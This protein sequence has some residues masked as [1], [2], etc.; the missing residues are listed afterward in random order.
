MH[1]T[2]GSGENALHIALGAENPDVQLIVFL[3]D[4][5]LDVDAEDSNGRTPFHCFCKVSRYSGY[6]KSEDVLTLLLSRSPPG[7]EKTPSASQETIKMNG[8]HLR[9]TNSYGCLSR[10][11]ANL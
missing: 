4:S 2:N 6:S 7:V 9:D 10:E 1:T 8:S 11:L 5:G 3:L